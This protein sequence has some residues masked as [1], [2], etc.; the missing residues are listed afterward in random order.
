[1]R[2]LHS[3]AKLPPNTA[4]LNKPAYPKKCQGSLAKFHGHLDLIR[5]HAGRLFS[6]EWSSNSFVV[7]D[8]NFQ[9]LVINFFKPGVFLGS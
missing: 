8:K 1:M 3:N 6:S 5:S 2:S 9:N 7:V 4:L